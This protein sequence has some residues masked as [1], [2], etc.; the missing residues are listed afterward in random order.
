[1]DRMNRTS[2]LLNDDEGGYFVTLDVFHQLH[3]LNEIRKQIYRDHYPT[4][5]SPSEQLEH[6]DHCVDMLRQV[7]MCHGDVSIQTYEWIDDYRWPWP[8]FHTEHECRNWEAIT[9]WAG[10]RYIG[11]IIGPIFT[12]PT[13]GTFYLLVILAL[14]PEGLFLNKASPGERRTSSEACSA[15]HCNM[16]QA[17]S[18]QGFWITSR[19]S[20]RDQMLEGAQI[21]P[22]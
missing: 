11:S 19:S 8:R 7:L 1:M 12:H 18:E 5:H 15:L 22:H 9:E 2:I 17:E 21:T 4:Q 6:A 13:L 20:G 16:H 3:C 10:Q 14:I